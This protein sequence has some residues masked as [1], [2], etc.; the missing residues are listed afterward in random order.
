MG[1]MS[2][3]LKLIST[4]FDGTFFSE[5]DQPPVANELVSLIA[6]LQSRGTRWAINTG[7]DLSSLMETLARAHLPIKPDYVVVVEREVYRHDQSRYVPVEDWNR[8][9]D[10]AHAELFDQI[11]TQ[12][13]EIIGWINAR[14]EA[15]IFEDAWSPLCLVAESPADAE[16]IHEYLDGYCDRVPHLTVT[17]ND[18]YARLS[19]AA[20]NK[21]TALA[22]VAG[23]L[24]VNPAEI[25]AAG[26][27]LND[28]P[29]LR[30]EF[31]ARLVAPGN[32]V[33]AVKESVRRQGGFVSELPHGYG[34]V[35][36]L[37]FH[38]NS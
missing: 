20:F 5:F 19:H 31:A 36:G 9:C 28:L 4:D 34:L 24:G 15:S 22:R 25:L 12:L 32:A 14:C 30:T 1:A 21:G 35:E 33:E 26:D 7:R 17:R 11:R 29:M 8:A 6:D 13:P 10:R 23:L 37:R 18:V 2:S 16:S 27:H 3:W 38:L